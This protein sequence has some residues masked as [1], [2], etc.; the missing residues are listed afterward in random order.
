MVAHLFNT[1]PKRSEGSWSKNVWEIPDHKGKQ[2]TG[3][4]HRE[5][6]TPRADPGE[7][8]PGR[9]SYGGRKMLRTTLRA[10]STEPNMLALPCRTLRCQW[11]CEEYIA[12][13]DALTPHWGHGNKSTLTSLQASLAGFPLA[14]LPAFRLQDQLSHLF[15]CASLWLLLPLFPAS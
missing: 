12:S 11:Q 9:K 3:I 6:K 10:W 8:R 13:T 7:L 14:G 1:S 5:R 2:P 4:N 15:L